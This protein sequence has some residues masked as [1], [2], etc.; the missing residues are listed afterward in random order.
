MDDW[1][2]SAGKECRNIEHVHWL[3]CS[4]QHIRERPPYTIH[5]L[6]TRKQ[7]NQLS[8]VCTGRRLSMCAWDA[9]KW[10]TE[11]NQCDAA[12]SLT[13]STAGREPVSE[14]VSVICHSLDYTNENGHPSVLSLRDP[15]WI[16]NRAP[17]TGWSL[18]QSIRVVRL[19]L[20]LCPA[21]FLPF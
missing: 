13:D 1:K 4:A 19:Y 21:A 18:L 5:L 2:R 6:H 12:S 20:R 8:G 14:R 3:D 9:G 11:W 17:S 10:L 7:N 16:W 15:L